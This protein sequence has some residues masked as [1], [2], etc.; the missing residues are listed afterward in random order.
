[1]LNGT[2]D[3]TLTAS[4]PWDELQLP[5]PRADFFVRE[6]PI[7]G[8]A[9][10]A[11][12]DG[13]SDLPFRLICRELGS[14]M[15]YT[16]FTNADGILQ[17]KLPDSV[18]HRL[19]FDPS[20]NPMTF[21]IYHHDADRLVDAAKRVLEL[22]PQI[23][24]LNMGCYVKDIA[25]RGAGSG[26]LRFP[27]RIAHYFS[28][29]SRELPIPVTGKIRL[30]WDDDSRNYL[31]TAKIIEDNG[32]SLIAVHARTK[33]QAYHGCADWDALAQIK[34]TVKIPV[35]GNGD[36]KT[37][38]DVARMKEY[39][40]CDGVMIGR[41][42]IGNP[43]IFSRRNRG[44]V[45]LDERVTLLRR[46]LTLNLDFYGQHGGLVLFRKHAVKYIHGLPGE[47]ALRVPLLT[48]ES[49]QHF[50]DLLAGF[51]RF[52]HVENFREYQAL[53]REFA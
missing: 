20:E 15:S 46:H 52:E 22:G 12:M 19:K 23:I 39:T 42:A 31:T 10:L 41:A 36:V 43:W 47:K 11:P 17:K 26:M 53:A 9:I 4:S 8:D 40:G 45:S 28:R 35:L 48:A 38:A 16:E 44:Q 5:E 32:A 2:L 6:I 27:E 18:A 29:A 24:D 30:G 7:F 14:A 49:V 1:M 3:K 51:E 34:Q 33:A 21:Q 50:D 37:V 25:E 13:F